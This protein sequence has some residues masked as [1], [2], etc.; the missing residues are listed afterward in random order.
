MEKVSLI[1]VSV[2][3]NRLAIRYKAVPDLPCGACVCC[4]VLST[5]VWRE[6]V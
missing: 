3:Y 6:G 2:L 1:S 4:V 5:A